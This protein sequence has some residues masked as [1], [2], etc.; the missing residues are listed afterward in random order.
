MSLPRLL[1]I[2]TN[3]IE[4]S[5]CCICLHMSLRFSLIDDDD[6]TI[7]TKKSVSYNVEKDSSTLIFHTLIK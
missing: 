6:G 2:P 4:L 7:Y 3:L 1:A 5:N